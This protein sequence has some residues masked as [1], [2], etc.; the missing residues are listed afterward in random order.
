VVPQEVPQKDF[1]DALDIA[2]SL[3]AGKIVTES[4]SLSF[5]IQREAAESLLNEWKANRKITSLH[6]TREMTASILG[7]VID[8][9]LSDVEGLELEFTDGPESVQKSLSDPKV[10]EVTV[11]LQSLAGSKPTLVLEKFPLK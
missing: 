4:L 3:R 5:G 9:G 11:R 6:F 8:L 2:K 10:E 1:Y 7:R